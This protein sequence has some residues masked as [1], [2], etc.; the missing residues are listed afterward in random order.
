MQ[1]KA[2]GSVTEGYNSSEKLKQLQAERKVLEDTKKDLL[3]ELSSLDK[4]IEEHLDIEGKNDMVLRA[5][6][7]DIEKYNLLAGKISVTGSGVVV[8]LENVDRYDNVYG[9]YDDVGLLY[10][11]ANYLLVIVNLLKSADAEAIC[12]N[13]GE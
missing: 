9:S 13:N 6:K 1:F 5:I 10:D 3:E 8:K 4:T 11:Y 12:I 2:V 7:E